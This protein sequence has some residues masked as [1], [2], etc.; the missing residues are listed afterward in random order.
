[1]AVLTL[2]QTIPCFQTFVITS[3]FFIL[4]HAYILFC[5]VINKASHNGL[6]NLKPTSW[7]RFQAPFNINIG[8]VIKVHFIQEEK[9][10]AISMIQIQM[11]RC[12]KWYAN[13]FFMNHGIAPAYLKGEHKGH[14]T[15]PLY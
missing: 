10:E 15:Y 3:A 2:P 14:T 12:G 13:N 1:M 9:S 4:S 8:T 11:E 7:S 6:L 5:G